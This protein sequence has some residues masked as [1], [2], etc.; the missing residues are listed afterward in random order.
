MGQ[1]ITLDSAGRI[2]LPAEVRRRLNLRAGARLQLE[3]VAERIELTPEPEAEAKLARSAGA[4]TV[5]RATG[6]ES[7]S[8]AAT[9]AE[10]DAQARRGRRR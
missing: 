10:R 7:D 4:R 8:A 2:V 6:K 9:R 5:L 1:P 3:V